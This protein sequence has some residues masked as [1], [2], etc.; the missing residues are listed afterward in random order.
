[1]KKFAIGFGTQETE[2][3]ELK[4][5]LGK[6]VSIQTTNRDYLG[7]VIRVEGPQVELLPYKKLDYVE[8]GVPFHKIKYSGKPFRLDKGTI[9]NFEGSSLESAKNLCFYLNKKE[10]LEFLETEK[11]LSQIEKESNKNLILKI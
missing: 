9:V 5:Y 7:K 1:M 2:V 8:G 11:R 6:W 4:D 10:K 3:I